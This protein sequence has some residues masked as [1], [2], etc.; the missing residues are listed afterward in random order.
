MRRTLCAALI[1]LVSPL[2]Q[3][4]SLPPVDQTAMALAE[5]AR[6]LPEE[7]R[8]QATRAA[9]SIILLSRFNRLLPANLDIATLEELARVFLVQKNDSER[10]R[11]MANR[12]PPADS[13][14]FDGSR[15]VGGNF[16][17]IDALVG[18]DSRPIALD[19]DLPTWIVP[20]TP[21]SAAALDARQQ[22]FQSSPASAATTNLANNIYQADVG[23]KLAADGIFLRPYAGRIDDRYKIGRAHV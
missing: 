20:L 2:A 22:K 9:L 12:L 17:N 3:A 14:I 21:A 1:L 11:A 5:A 15:L 18:M 19:R 8:L 13:L 16:R 7:E 23:G 4:A 6:K 10:Q